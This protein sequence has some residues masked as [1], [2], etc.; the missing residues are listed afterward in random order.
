MDW[1][2]HNREVARKRWARVLER[3]LSLF[4]QRSAEYPELKARV[5]GYLMG[6]G[7]VTVRRDGYGE[8]HDIGFYPDDIEMLDSFLDAFYQLYGELPQVRIARNYYRIRVH[9]K[10][11]VVHLLHHG[12]FRSLEW[13]APHDILTNESTRREWL[14]AMYDCEGYVGPKVIAFQTVNERGL[15]DIRLLL[16]EFGIESRTYTYK[17]KQE[18]WNRNF[19]LYITRKTARRTFL[20]EIGFHHGK[21]QEKL[22]KFAAIA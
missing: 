7:S 6:D 10:P 20:K 12:S 2:V 17:R 15:N 5:V 14:R 11:M 22:L 21:K 8:H 18:A 1:S 16:A 19:L 4:E 3:K 9:S 13:R